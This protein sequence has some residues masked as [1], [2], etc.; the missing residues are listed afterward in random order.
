MEQHVDLKLVKSIILAASFCAVCYWGVCLI[1]L[2][3]QE[4]ID[5]FA[6]A[7]VTSL[8]IHPLKEWIQHYFIIAYSSTS[9]G[10]F[11]PYCL[12][13][14]IPLVFRPKYGGVFVGV[15]AFIVYKSSVSFFLFLV[16]ALLTVDLVIK[17][18]LGI[19]IR[20]TSFINIYNKT[21][22]FDTILTIF[23][24][25]FLL[26]IAAI[27]QT[28]VFGSI[29]LELTQ[30][31]KVLFDFFSSFVDEDPWETFKKSPYSQVLDDN[32]GEIWRNFT[33]VPE[34]SSEEYDRYVNSGKSLPIVGGIIERTSV[35]LDFYLKDIGLSSGEVIF[36][37]NLPQR[38]ELLWKTFSYCFKT[39]FG[40]LGGVAFVI[41]YALEKVI[42]YFTL[43]YILVKDA[44]GLVE[45]AIGLIPLSQQMQIEISSD[46]KK[47]VSGITISFILAGSI[48]YI[49]TLISFSLL[50]LEFKYLFS[51]L[52]A[53]VGLFPYVGT[54]VVT[55]PMVIYLSLSGSAKGIILLSIEYFVINYLDGEV[56]TSQLGYFNQSMIGIVIVLGIYKFGFLGIFYG[57]LIMSLGYLIFKIGHTLNQQPLIS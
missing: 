3:L 39:L 56:Y 4:Y 42:L 44:G 25:V 35:F 30:K 5:V 43:V 2:L 10:P 13:I 21:Q 20:L 51:G 31:G 15:A 11:L 38:P 26:V 6:I 45:K 29:A 52:A 40:N 7:F 34:E 33:H 47:T 23:L 32:L 50:E 12:I 17:L 46:I 54:W 37:L 8:A 57:P 9:Y 24:I 53:S 28:F 14:D 36:L 22:I 16:V 55:L 41:S 18:A 48:H 49:V 19:L 27:L 1:F